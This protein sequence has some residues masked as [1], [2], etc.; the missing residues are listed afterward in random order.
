MRSWWGELH[1]ASLL[2][3]SGVL[4][5]VDSDH[6]CH[7][8]LSKMFKAKG[9]HLREQI[10]LLVKTLASTFA[11]PYLIDSLTTWRLIPLNKN[12]DVIPI[13]LGKVLRQVI[14]KTINCILQ[15]DIQET[16]QSLQTAT[17]LKASAGAAIHAMGTIFEEPSTE[18]VI[19][20]ETSNAFNS[21][22][23]KVALRNNQIARPS[24]GHILINTYR[25]SSWMMVMG[26][27][28][29]QSIEGRQQEDSLAM[30]FYAIAAVQI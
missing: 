16:V 8:L 26:G 15:D 20:V 6:F 23:W 28:E 21:F 19:P 29:I 27:S 13:G 5:N 2:K 7:M 25:S 24:F 4:S 3:G 9:K 14:G 10:A 12:P 17:V 1:P 22:N 11:N 30:S 18:G